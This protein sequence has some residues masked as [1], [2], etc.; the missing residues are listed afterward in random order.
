V[1]LFVGRQTFRVSIVS[2]VA[3]CET[4]RSNPALLTRP[5]SVRT[6]VG[7]DVFA[8]FTAAIGASLPDSTMDNIT[9]LSELSEEF[10]RLTLAAHIEDFRAGEIQAPDPS[11]AEIELL[12]EKQI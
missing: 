10:G 2:V 7:F 3:T 1:A 6:R 11:Q 4:F 5:Y 9:S 12:K 8:M